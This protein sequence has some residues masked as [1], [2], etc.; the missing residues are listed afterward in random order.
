MK[1][2]LVVWDFS[3]LVSLVDTFSGLL[4]I[5]IRN[6]GCDDLKL[7]YPSTLNPWEKV[8]IHKRTSKHA[9][10]HTLSLTQTPTAQSRTLINKR[11]FEELQLVKK[12][13]FLTMEIFHHKGRDTITTHTKQN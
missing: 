2:V 8:I 11:A 5:Y 9:C 3:G 10:I 1:I 12:R 7:I 6:T 13:G 4:E